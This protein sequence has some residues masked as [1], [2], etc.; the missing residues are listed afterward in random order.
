MPILCCKKLVYK[1]FLP[2]SPVLTLITSEISE[3]KIFPSPILPVFAAF[4]IDSTALSKSS[5]LTTISILTFGR[6][7]TMYSA[8]EQALHSGEPVAVQDALLGSDEVW[9]RTFLGTQ[10]INLKLYWIIPEILI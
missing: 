4:C 10:K 2:V 6:K 9:V 5:S 7:S 8:P 1:A 3:I